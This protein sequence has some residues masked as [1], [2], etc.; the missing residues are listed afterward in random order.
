MSSLNEPLAR[1]PENGVSHQDPV[2]NSSERSSSE[3]SFTNHTEIQQVIEERLH[4]QPVPL[5][6]LPEAHRSIVPL[7]PLNQSSADQ[8]RNGNIEQSADKASQSSWS[9]WG[10]LKSTTSALTS[11]A[12][13]LAKESVSFVAKGSVMSA[14][15]SYIWLVDQLFRTEGPIKQA[16]QEM[17]EAIYAAL[18]NSDLSA[19]VKEMHA[20]QFIEFHNF[21]SNFIAKLVRENASNADKLVHINVAHV[22]VNLAKRIQQE[23]NHY[24]LYQSQSPLSSLISLVCQCTSTFKQTDP[25]TG[26]TIEKKLDSAL[27][28]I[29]SSLYNHKDKFISDLSNSQQPNAENPD[30][31]RQQNLRLLALNI[32]RADKRQE[33]V[34]KLFPQLE[35]IPLWV[36]SQLKHIND[37]EVKRNEQ[38]KDLFSDIADHVLT[39]FLPNK[40]D[41]IYLPAISQLG[42]GAHGGYNWVRERAATVGLCTDQPTDLGIHTK[43]YD[44]VRSYVTDFLLDCYQGIKEDLLRDQVW[45]RDIQE[46]IGNQGVESLISAPNLLLEGFLKAYIQTDP[47]AVELIEKQLNETSKTRK[48]SSTEQE[49]EEAVTQL[50]QRQTA[51]WIVDSMKAMFQTQD[52]YLLEAGSV[53]RKTIKTFTLGLLAKGATFAIPQIQGQL[54]EDK[55]LTELF[56]GFSKM[57]S[58]SPVDQFLP[59]AQR[60]VKILT[61]DSIAVSD[62]IVKEFSKKIYQLTQDPTIRS[63]LKKV[64]KLMR[65]YEQLTGTT[66]STRFASMIDQKEIEEGYRNIE[67]QLNQEVLDKVS[68]LSFQEIDEEFGKSLI[69]HLPIPSNFQDFIAELATKKVKSL[70]KT[71]FAAVDSLNIKQIYQELSIKIERYEGGV[72]LKQIS[73][74]ISD[75]FANWI[76]ENGKSCIE[77]FKLEEETLENLCTQYLP[78]VKINPELIEWFK[79][80]MS[81]LGEANGISPASTELLKQ[82]IQTVLLA[83]FMKTLEEGPESVNRFFSSIHQAFD[84]A[85]SAL[86]SQVN[87][88]TLK[89]AIPI[90]AKIRANLKK[91]EQLKTFIHELR[92][93]CQSSN[94]TWKEEGNEIFS[95]QHSL[96]KISN[97]FSYLEEEYNRNMQKLGLTPDRSHISEDLKRFKEALDYQKQ[98]QSDLDLSM[99]RNGFSLLTAIKK[100]QELEDSAVKIINGPEEEKK[101]EDCSLITNLISLY[102]NFTSDKINLIGKTLRL[103]RSLKEVS[104]QQEA[105]SKQVYEQREALSKKV[106]ESEQWQES[107]GWWVLMDQIMNYRT[108]IINLDQ[109]NIRLAKD[110]EQHLAPF[111]TLAQDLM[112]TVGLSLKSRLVPSANKILDL[113]VVEPTPAHREAFSQKL[114]ELMKDS[115]RKEVSVTIQDVR[116]AYD[117][118]KTSVGPLKERKITQHEFELEA[119]IEELCAP[120]MMDYIWPQIESAEEKVIA[121]QLLEYFA[122]FIL[123]IQERQQH[124]ETLR[125]QTGSDLLGNMCASLSKDM[126]RKIPAYTTSEAIAQ[127]LNPLIPGMEGLHRL[128]ASQLQAVVNGQDPVSQRNQE[129]LEKY[130]ESMLLQIFLRAIQ[131]N[132]REGQN[133]LSVVAE[134]LTDLENLSSDYDLSQLI[135]KDI[136]GLRTEDDLQTLPPALRGHVFKMIQEQVHTQLSPLLIPLLKREENKRRL[137]TCSG[138]SFLSDFSQALSQGLVAKLPEFIQ[139]YYSMAKLIFEKLD[140]PCMP[141]EIQALANKI[142]GRIQALPSNKPLTNKDLA[143]AY[144]E[145]AREFGDNRRL[146]QDPEVKKQIKANHIK[147][148]ISAIVMTPEEIM[149][150]IESILPTAG[151]QL[152]ASLVEGLASDVLQNF[153]QQNGVAYDQATT[154][155]QSYIESILFKVFTRIAEKNPPVEGKDV[156]VVMTEKLLQIVQNQWQRSTNATDLIRELDRCIMQD[157]LGI[158]SEAVFEGLP[159]DIQSWAYDMVKGQIGQ[160][161]LQVQGVL[162]NMEKGQFQVE[163][164][165]QKIAKLIGGA[166]GAVLAK[167]IGQLAL[168]LVPH[169]LSATS[170]DEQIVGAVKIGSLI[171]NYLEELKKANLQVGQLL[172]NY[173]GVPTLQRLLGEN[174]QHLAQQGNL[175]VEKTYAAEIVGNL[176]LV[177][178]ST[179]LTSL[180]ITE[181]RRKEEL[182][183]KFFVNIL[184]VMTKHFQFLNRARAQAKAEGRKNFT[185]QDFV[186]AAGEELHPATARRTVDYKKFIAEINALLGH[187]LQG[188][189]INALEKELAI[190]VV[191]DAKGLQPLTDELI[192]KRVEKYNPSWTRLK[193]EEKD[194]ILGLDLKNRILKEVKEIEEKAYK[195]E[196]EHFYVPFNK[197]LLSVL[198]PG[199]RNGETFVGLIGDDKSMRK[200][201][202]NLLK[203][204]LPTL[205]PMIIEL[206]IDQDMITKL[207]V[208]TIQNIRI[209]LKAANC[210]QAVQEINEKLSGNLTDKQQEKLREEL[211][212]LVSDEHLY[213]GFAKAIN[214]DLQRKLTPRQ[215]EELSQMMS[216]VAGNIKWT[217]K[218]EEDK[219]A[220]KD[221]FMS[222]CDKKASKGIFN[223]V[224]LLFLVSVSATLLLE[225]VPVLRD[226]WIAN[227]IEKAGISVK[228]QEIGKILAKNNEGI[229]FKIRL[230]EESPIIQNKKTPPMDHTQ[231]KLSQVA[232]DLVTEIVESAQLPPQIAN[233]LKTMK[234]ENGQLVYGEMFVNQIMSMASDRFMR[235]TAKILVKNLAFHDPKTGEATLKFKAKYSMTKEESIKYHTMKEEEAIEYR[236][237]LKKDLA[238]EPTALLKDSIAYG[239]R[240]Y[241]TRVQQSW[242]EALDKTLPKIASPVRK[243]LT[244]VFHFVFYKVIGTA[245]NILLSPVHFIMKKLVV[246]ASSLLLSPLDFMIKK[247]EL[248]SYSEIGGKIELIIDT[249]RMSLN[250]DKHVEPVIDAIREIPIDQPTGQDYY[251]AYNKDLAFKFLEAWSKAMKEEELEGNVAS[252]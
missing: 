126:I 111:K 64:R 169:V 23:S 93:K 136:L 246:T 41:S 229:D 71:L 33:I 88:Q 65:S 209:S 193:K 151:G 53:I 123:S 47:T 83:S 174:I 110:L 170:P 183:Q 240:T 142:S 204:G 231:N 245:L 32:H 103:E 213:K 135:V 76:I 81:S 13:H 203:T 15:N 145:V 132:S 35:S 7:P 54:A 219:Q 214:E 4:N 236:K 158:D 198:F 59:F 194:A 220:L 43:I 121:P 168:D 104:Q 60:A 235:E 154:L 137:D 24:P 107:I 62:A 199:G 63:P 171:G 117:E 90:Q 140:I 159:P 138:S 233:M 184:E 118:V 162:K 98:I 82:G 17:R 172:L 26:K 218:A 155:I 12:W 179:A 11:T 29:E 58:L 68:Q 116:K 192:L 252:V 27:K 115:V 223:D 164:S 205:L 161:L 225:G 238:K 195:Q 166:Q 182:N 239:V 73:S 222:E 70:Q 20:S 215:E 163:A 189:Q 38:L 74:A 186:A 19:T 42:Q 131:A 14:I 31:D 69:Q 210:T 177:P 211:A 21:V 122:P 91:Q 114:Y 124:R 84:R 48:I 25:E 85:L 6:S 227:A 217:G 157:V 92:K 148:K 79:R 141:D 9:V 94:V 185:Y 144:L 146:V 249:L 119:A 55:F 106:A 28:E 97:D 152:K 80:N 127:L 243:A 181:D 143:Q 207:V 37:L 89:N 102:E 16:K 150:K 56:N 133:I 120:S 196:Q 232:V 250:V 77:G 197:E 234:N 30:P 230:L 165:R 188:K 187:R 128:I 247:S 173:V 50:S 52:P 44:K 99:Q 51:E 149:T 72:G 45:K 39:I 8:A 244:T 49:I 3:E 175:K 180:A 139:S 248:S 34:N 57:V 156:L 237:G 160:F 67:S 105:L 100:K 147:E 130:L 108:D 113:L 216:A 251:G 78:G 208:K 2:R 40:L 167:D 66:I 212:K 241:W 228:P 1:L 190:L 125:N 191:K 153:F 46:R 18:Q 95:L 109:A 22:F 134:K 86:S 10:I 5:E 206:L 61:N 36:D 202:W 224:D 112:A 226:P 75:L 101:Q 201:V 129:M 87:Q 96:M 221:A 200:L 242:N 176:V 178:L